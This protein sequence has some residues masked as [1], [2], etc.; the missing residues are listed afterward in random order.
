MRKTSTTTT[1]IDALLEDTAVCID[2]LD[3]D[4]SSSQ[5]DMAAL[6]GHF[7]PD[8]DAQSSHAP[9]QNIGQFPRS[10]GLT[11]AVSVLLNALLL[12]GIGWFVLT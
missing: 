3:A 4:L 9:S 5:A 11:I 12:G 2:R 6:R 10:W 8:T 1:T 7:L